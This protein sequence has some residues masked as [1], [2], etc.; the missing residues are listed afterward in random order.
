VPSLGRPSSSG[1]GRVCIL[2]AGN[3]GTKTK[4]IQI[5]EI[6]RRNGLYTLFAVQKMVKDVGEVE[7]VKARV[8]KCNA[9]IVCISNEFLERSRSEDDELEDEH[10]RQLVYHALQKEEEKI[11]LLALDAISADRM[12][13]EESQ[14]ERYI[15][16]RKVCLDFQHRVNEVKLLKLLPA[17]LLDSFSPEEEERVGQ[18]F[19]NKNRSTNSARTNSSSIVEMKLDR[20][21]RPNLPGAN[22]SSF[23][24]TKKDAPKKGLL[25][26]FWTMCFGPSVQST[27]ADVVEREGPEETKTGT[28]SSSQFESTSAGDDGDDSEDGVAP[29]SRVSG[30]N[31]LPKD[32]TR[33]SLRTSLMQRKSEKNKQRVL[34]RNDI[35]SGTERMVEEVCR[36]LAKRGRYNAGNGGIASLRFAELRRHFFRDLPEEEISTEDNDKVLIGVLDAAAIEGRL[37]YSGGVQ[38]PDRRDVSIITLLKR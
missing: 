2:N 35:R 9:V 10:W 16:S 8:N 7:K 37:K 18:R 38:I 25:D 28:H 26:S 23:S 13:W 15:Y 24:D 29:Y 17:S 1:P 20:P 14:L 6:L 11:I 5:G 21:A 22:Q 27:F 32:E 3:S 34:R 4:A 19:S 30:V 33:E 12:N 31:S 36:I